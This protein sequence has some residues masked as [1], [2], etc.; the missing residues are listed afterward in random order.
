MLAKP[1]GHRLPEH[2]EGMAVEPKWDGFR[3]LVFRGPDG[4]TLQGRGRSQG[5][6]GGARAHQGVA[7]LS[8]A[9]P[10]LVEACLTQLEPGTIVDGEIVLPLD[11]RLD[12]S[13]LSSRLRPRSEA[14]G[15]NIAR[16][17]ASLPVTF[18]AFDLLWL[19]HDLMDRPLHERRRAL[20]Q[21]ARAWHAPL[22]LGPQTTDRRVAE[23]W[24][25]A[26]ESAGVDGLIVKALDEPYRPGVRT[27]G[28][29][30]HQRT[31]DVV[32]AG[33]RPHTRTGPDGT[34][35]VGSLRLGHHDDRGALH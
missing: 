3:C 32:V 10:E 27:Q 25:T 22:L 11:G 26:F 15:A 6:S 5:T 2:L 35:I 1:L 33:W 17:A 18:L 23:H 14:G 19:G 30:K 12:F 24:F 8:H 21:A 29:V 34:P 13:A 7:D 16:L 28:K 4:V 31:A 9:F 20:E